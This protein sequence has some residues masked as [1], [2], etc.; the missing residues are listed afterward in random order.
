MSALTI[1]GPEVGSAQPSGSAAP[2]PPSPPAPPATGAGA[3]ALPL[4]AGSPP[5]AS[6][7]PPLPPSPRDWRLPSSDPQA[8]KPEITNAAEI[9]QIR[10]LMCATVPH[11]GLLRPVQHTLA[12]DAYCATKPVR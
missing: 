8:A 3:P 9:G 7:S 10:L 1:V 4:T 12:H 5:L 6:A 11:S 2:S